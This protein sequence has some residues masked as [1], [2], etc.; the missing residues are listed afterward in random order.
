MQPTILQD[1]P[2]Y[3]IFET[4]AV[5]DRT[6]SIEKGHYV[7]KDVDYAV[8]IPSG[9]KDRIEQIVGEWFTKLEEAVAQ[10]RFPQAWLLGYRQAYQ[11][12]KSG[13]EI[14][15]AGTSVKNWPILSPAQVKMLLGFNVRTVEDLAAANENT[16]SRIGMGGRA[17]KDKAIAWLEHQSGG[18][19]ALAEQLIAARQ[20]I[21]AL[22]STVSTLE[23]ALKEAMT[24][25][26]AK[27]GGEIQAPLP[28][29]AP[30][31]AL[32]KKAA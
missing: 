7:A 15:E 31:P 6:V 24:L 23:A 5:E 21:E 11:A 14:P 19:G 28:A 27:E 9:A 8:I 30:S 12:W 29:P 18:G 3:V 20:E 2:P 16:I 22:K 25:M 1:K 4:R 32:A 13:Q 10:E 17:L 26:K